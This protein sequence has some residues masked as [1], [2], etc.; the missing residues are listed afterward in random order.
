MHTQR[1]SAFTLIELLVV[2]AIIAILIGLL[3]PA[4]QKIREAAARMSC[5]N[6]LKQI[7]L[8]AHA[9]ESSNGFLPAGMDI[10]S[11]GPL[12]FMLPFLEQGPQFSLYDKN[13]GLWFYSPTNNPTVGSATIPRPPARYGAEG[14]IRTFLCPSAPPSNNGPVGVA[15]Y[16]GVSGVDFPSGINPPPSGSQTIYYD[17]GTGSRRAFG[18]CNY[19]ANGGDWRTDLGIRYRFRGP[20]YWKSK[21]RISNILDGT[22]YTLFFGEASGGGDPFNQIPWPGSPTPIPNPSTWTAYSWAIGPTYTSF[23]IGDQQFGGANDWAQFASKHPNL[24]QFAYADGSV[25]Q[26]TGLDRYNNSA[27]AVLRA[28]SGMNDGVTFDGVD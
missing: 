11:S 17:T 13:A 12:V 25:R 7:A 5:Q 19:L 28:V 4:V 3:L 23:G 10:H 8:A 9:F 6:N 1:R 2:I 26:L 15:I 14:D 24:I 21:E 27:Y 18:R 22:S 20:F 16:C